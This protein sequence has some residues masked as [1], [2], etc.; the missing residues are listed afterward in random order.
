M[1]P[2]VRK[3][4]ANC[5][6]HIHTVARHGMR[7]AKKFAASDSRKSAV[8]VTNGWLRNCSLATVYHSYLHAWNELDAVTETTSMGES[9]GTNLKPVLPI[10]FFFNKF[11][12]IKK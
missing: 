1:L 11:M 9:N 2:V 12:K 7:K 10:A 3:T 8:V 4:S 5:Y 6:D